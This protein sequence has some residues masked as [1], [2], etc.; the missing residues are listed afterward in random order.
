MHEDSS[1]NRSG[2]ALQFGVKLGG[3]VDAPAPAAV[4]YS[5]PDNVRCAREWARASLLIR[6]SC[7]HT[8]GGGYEGGLGMYRTASSSC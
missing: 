5:T 4:S 6:G 3:T 8:F 1:D 2:A 7:V